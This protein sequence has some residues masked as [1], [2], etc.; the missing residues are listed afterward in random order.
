MKTL[1][2]TSEKELIAVD[3]NDPVEVTT[4][5]KQIIVYEIINNIPKIFC[6]LNCTIGFITSEEE[7]QNYLD[8]NGYEDEKFNFKRL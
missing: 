7:I 2:Y 1:Y 5:L 6:E 4:G 3:D 8:D